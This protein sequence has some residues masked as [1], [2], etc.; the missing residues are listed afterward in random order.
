[1]LNQTSDILT[2]EIHS[3]SAK[4]NHPVDIPKTIV[5]FGEVEE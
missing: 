3:Q 4:I 1:V 2:N 5:D